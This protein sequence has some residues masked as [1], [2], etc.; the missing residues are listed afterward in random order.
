MDLLLSL[1]LIPFAVPLALGFVSMCCCA[2]G[3]TRCTSSPATFQADITG[4]TD[5]GTCTNCTWANA[6]WIIDYDGE[7]SFCDWRDDTGTQNCN[8]GLTTT[9]NGVSIQQSESGGNYFTAVRGICKSSLSGAFV[10][11]IDFR[12]E[13]GAT[14]PDCTFFSATDIPWVTGIGGGDGCDGAMAFCSLTA[15]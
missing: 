9:G 5:S 14:K 10:S 4:V 7:S 12:Y 6:T 11:Q 2:G 1:L 3:C 15:L 13:H 8:C